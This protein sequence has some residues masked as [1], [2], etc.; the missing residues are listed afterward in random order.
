[1]PDSASAIEPVAPIV[2]VGGGLSG[3][4]LAT[5]LLEAPGRRHV[6]VVDDAG[7]PGRGLAYSVQGRLHLVNANAGRMSADP[8]D[9]GHFTKWLERFVRNGGWPEAP[10]EPAEALFAPRSVYGLYAQEVL[11]ETVAANAS[12]GRR[13]EWLPR[14]ATDLVVTADNLKVRLLDDTDLTASAVVLA[15]GIFS[16]ARALPTGR[17]F[18]RILDPWAMNPRDIPAPDARIAIVGAGLTMVDAV[19]SL[20][21]AGHSGPIDVY[22]RQGLRPHPRRLPPEWHDFL[23]DCSGI[24]SIRELTRRVRRECEKALASGEDWQSPLDTVK[25]HIPRLW[26]SATDT[27]RRCFVRHL[28]PFWESHHHRS[29]P[30]AALIVEQLVQSG[31]L[32]HVRA[33]VENVDPSIR[34]VTL[35]VR[36]RGETGRQTHVYDAVVVSSGVDYDWTRV[37]QSLP[38]NLLAG[39]CVRPGPLGLGIDAMPDFH[40]IDRQG[41]PH[42]RLFAIGPPL[43]GLW[44]ES[45]AVVDVARQALDIATLLSAPDS[46]GLPETA[47]PGIWHSSR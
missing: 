34:S 8:N 47:P 28:R 27:E 12:R 40:V 32:R 23:T 29:P 39:G 7:P 25:A 22:S 44:W 46:E 4:L 16:R 36:P 30:A 33:V 37:E 9:P 35:Q 5:R 1:M 19:V 14:R 26:S 15:T 2:I 17:S 3:A 31:R 38:R 6:V 10:D 24:N 18:R 43:R 41:I 11:A 20:Q 45:T 13:F 21:A 42:Q